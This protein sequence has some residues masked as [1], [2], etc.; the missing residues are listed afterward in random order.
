MKKLIYILLIALSVGF[1]FTACGDN[2]KPDNPPTVQPEPK[3]EP[4]VEKKLSEKVAGEWHCK[5]S[6]M[7]ADIYVSFVSDGTFELYQQITEGAYRL[8]RGTW[9]TDED[10]KIITGKYND[11]EAWASNYKAS[12]S[13]DEKN[14]TL[15]STVG[16]VKNTYTRESI[17]ASVK[18]N[19]VVMVK[20][21]YAY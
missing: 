9:S 12:V 8:Y 15:E 14:M 6:D 20:S 21:P 17:P 7:T 1:L 11:G 2:H 10:N 13:E 16:A 18:E 5:A 4:P 3:P 19:C